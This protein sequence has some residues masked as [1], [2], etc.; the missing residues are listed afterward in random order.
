MRTKPS[1]YLCLLAAS[2]LLAACATLQPKESP[3]VSL[4]GVK[5]I[6]VGLLEQ[7]FSLTLRIQ[8]PNRTPLDIEGLSFKVEIDGK[9]FARGVSGNG[10][11]IPAFGEQLLT[12]EASST[13]LDLIDQLQRLQPDM[14]GLD[15][16]IHGSISPRGSLT[17]VPF[18]R[19]GR[20]SGPSAAQGDE[21][22]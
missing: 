11:E 13:L 18:E 12:V 16:R 21:G 7:R 2:L 8:N 3:R 6:G 17:N 15:Y 22:R 5:L 14:N 9:D 4:V 20:L 19:S 1:V 10:A